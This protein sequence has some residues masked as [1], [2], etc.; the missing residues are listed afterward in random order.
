MYVRYTK[1][2]GDS[3]Y[4]RPVKWCNIYESSACMPVNDLVN[5]TLIVYINYQKPLYIAVSANMP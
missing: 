5:I 2:S 3:V 1:N 4:L